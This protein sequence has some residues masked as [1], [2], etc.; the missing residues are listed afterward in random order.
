[1]SGRLRWPRM[2]GR[3]RWPRMSGRRGALAVTSLMLLAGGC[4]PG[5]PAAADGHSAPP[6]AVTAVPS[7]QLKAPAARYLAIAVPAS[8]R[9]DREVDGFA[10][11]QRDDLAAAESDLRAEA[12]T[13][14]WFDRRLAEIRFPAGIAA[15]ARAMIQVNESRAVLADREAQAT[16]LAELRSFATQHAAADAATEFGVRLIRRALGLPP[17]ST[18]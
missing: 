10:D 2:S 13:E 8:H 3:L 5:A 18:S 7:G 12:T 16:S 4:S 14:R 17:P 9:L 6:A 11:A 15:M 1:M